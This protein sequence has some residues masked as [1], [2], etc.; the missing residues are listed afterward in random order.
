MWR[1]LKYQVKTTNLPQ[2]IDKLNTIMFYQVQLTM[3]D[4][5][6]HSFSGDL[7]GGELPSPYLEIFFTVLHLGG[8]IN[9]EFFS[10]YLKTVYLYIFW[11]HGINMIMLFKD[12]NISL[13]FILLF[14]ITLPALFP[15][16]RKKTIFFCFGKDL[17]ISTSLLKSSMSLWSLSASKWN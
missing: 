15:V 17:R 16:P 8:L 3:W 6:A 14:G 1:T 9:L 10:I 4:N 12:F 5:Q 7:G 11:C 13:P 2:L